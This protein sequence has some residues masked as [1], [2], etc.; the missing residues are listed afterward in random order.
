MDLVAQLGRRSAHPQE[1]QC[2]LVFG[3]RLGLVVGCHLLRLGRQGCQCLAVLLPLA[4]GGHDTLVPAIPIAEVVPRQAA[5]STLAGAAGSGTCAVLGASFP[6][7]LQMQGSPKHP[8]VPYWHV[9]CSVTGIVGA[10]S[11]AGSAA[12]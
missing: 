4:S 6:F 10:E 5:L 1:L 2:C 7:P 3:D 8:A 12:S 11:S 9:T